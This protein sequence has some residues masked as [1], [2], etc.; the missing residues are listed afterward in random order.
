MKYK[1]INVKMKFIL[2]YHVNTCMLDQ[3]QV[4]FQEKTA[5]PSFLSQLS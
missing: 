5:V 2:Q 4:L 3:Y 1:P